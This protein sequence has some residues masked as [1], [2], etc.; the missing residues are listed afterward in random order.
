MSMPRSSGPGK[1]EPFDPLT[2]P[3]SPAATVLLVRD[4]ETGLDVFMLRRTFSAAFASGMYVFPGGR[5][6]DSDFHDELG[7]VCD[8]LTDE[9]ASSLL[10]I[11]RNG[12]SYWV[13]AIRECFEEAGVLLARHADSGDVVRFDTPEVIER[14]ER[15]RHLVHEGQLSLAQLCRQ[16]NLRL[17][18][19][20]IHYVSHWI[21]PA[22]ERRRFDTRFFVARAPQAQEPLHDDGETI[23]SLWVKPHEALSRFAAGDLQMLPPTISSLEFLLDSTTADDAL[24]AARKV[25]VPPVIEPRLRLN[26][27]GKVIAVVMPGESGYDELG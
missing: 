24:D 8:G 20:A 4:D 17:T 21:T 25:G 22:G 26:S 12:L 11:P 10:Q 19:D 1:D 16:E 14:F 13:A 5:V 3:I 27:D 6:D 7:E 23:E 15:A 9:H 18:T 2:V